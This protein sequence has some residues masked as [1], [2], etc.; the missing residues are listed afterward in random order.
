MRICAVSKFEASISR[1][2]GRGDKRQLPAEL[3]CGS[4]YTF[5]CPPDAGTIPPDRAF[6]P[7][8]TRDSHLLPL[9]KLAN[10]GEGLILNRRN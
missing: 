10:H 1:P 7:P 6:H 8:S 9:T 4:R 5:S 2:C 3:N